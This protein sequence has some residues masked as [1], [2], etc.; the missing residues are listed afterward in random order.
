MQATLTWDDRGG[1][2][3]TGERRAVI[4]STVL[5]GTVAQLV[6]LVSYSPIDGIF[7]IDMPGG[8][9]IWNDQIEEMAARPDCPQK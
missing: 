7:S 2:P 6:N 8:E 9:R 1:P 5:R 3:S 4:R